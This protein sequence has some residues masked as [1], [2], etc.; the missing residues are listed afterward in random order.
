MV[1]KLTSMNIDSELLKKAKQTML[2]ISEFV[3]AK[4][5]EKLDFSKQD[6][7]DEE[8]LVVCQ[9]CKTIMSEGYYRSATIEAPKKFWK[10]PSPPMLKRKNS[11][12]KDISSRRAL[13]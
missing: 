11:F 10:R 2:N 7:S 8:L 13:R 4:L 12:A 1:K 5:K 9:K 6:L 3:N